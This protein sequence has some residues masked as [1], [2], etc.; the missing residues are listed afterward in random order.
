VPQQLTAFLANLAVDSDTAK[1]FRGNQKTMTEQQ[2]GAYIDGLDL[3]DAAKTAIK[4]A[5]SA[6]DSTIIDQQL[7]TE[8]HQNGMSPIRFAVCGAI[9]G[10]YG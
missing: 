6:R 2:F 1:T 9:D 8:W 10:Y 7:I 3:S 4:S 5:V